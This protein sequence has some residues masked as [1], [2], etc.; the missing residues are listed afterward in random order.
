MATRLLLL[1]PPGAGK[2]TQAQLL[3]ER[4]GIP[5]IST[6]DMLRAAV[7]AGTELGRRAEAIMA[8]GDL[9]SDEIVVGVARERLG[10]SDCSAGFILD[11]FP[12]TVGQARALDGILEDF[13]SRLECCVAI[14][15][16]DEALVE[17]LVKRAAIEG[18]D[19]DDEA[20]IRHRMGVYHEQ[21]APLVDYYREQ[22]VLAEVDG[23]GSVEA[24]A[25]RVTEVIS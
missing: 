2:G 6:G 24:V 10:Q 20:T 5:Q 21:T 22:G 7:S 16:D 18:R 3:V 15:A 4:L 25:E 14:V 12:R 13:E 9:V 19:D 8:R 11:G 17:R 23:S 1:G